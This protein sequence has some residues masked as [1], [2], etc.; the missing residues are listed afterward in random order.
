MN[1]IIIL[2]KPNVGKSSLFNCFFKERIAITSDISGTTRD[3]NIKSIIINDIEALLCDTAG[4]VQKEEGFFIDIKQKVLSF[5]NDNDI[6]LYVI[7]GSQ[8]IDDYDIKLFRKLKNAT[9]V[10]NKIDKKKDGLNTWEY[11]IFGTKNIFFISSLHN[12]GL[13]SLKEFVSQKLNNAINQ[14]PILEDCIQDSNKIINIGIIGRVNVGKSS[15]LNALLNKER[16]VV[17]DIAGTTIDPVDDKIEYKD[18]I[19]NF[20]DTAGIRQRSK[21]EG[22]EKYAL[23]RTKKILEISNIVLLILDSSMPFVDL[24]EK[25]SGLSDKY[26]LGIIIVLNKWDIRYSEFQEIQKEIKRKFAYLSYA[27][28]ITASAT[29]KRHINDI[30]DMILEVYENYNRRIPTALL[31]STIKDATIR[32]PIPS[33]KGKMV[34]IYYA[35]QIRNAPPEIVLVMNK[36]KSLHFSYKRY[37]INYLRKSFNFKGS[38]IL[39]SP[40]AKSSK[41]NDKENKPE[42]VVES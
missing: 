30:K 9:L 28:I 37:L 19:L 14:D 2:G 41:F 22:I 33:D 26:N 27:P 40:K 34:K 7:D 32:H 31:N 24:D 17:S 39:I 29:N 42:S 4:I 20:V 38:P 13:H 12:K 21:I 35:T 25:I 5:V 10:I 18:K 15:I 11:G 3:I 6:V 16:S 1:K 36:P 23:D 8:G